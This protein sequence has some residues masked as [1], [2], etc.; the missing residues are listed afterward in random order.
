MIDA[1][2]AVGIGLCFYCILIEKQLFLVHILYLP[3]KLKFLNG[4]RAG[5]VYYKDRLSVSSDSA[6]SVKAVDT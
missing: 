4:H 2:P 1:A 3:Y 5:W 6:C